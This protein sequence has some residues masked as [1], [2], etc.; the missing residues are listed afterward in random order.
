[1]THEWWDSTCEPPLCAAA[2]RRFE[3][4]VRLFMAHAK[5]D[6]NREDWSRRSPLWYAASNGDDRIA[7]LLLDHPRTNPNHD[8]REG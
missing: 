1:V 5:I 4:V 8:D 7:Q 6:P 3:A 2:R